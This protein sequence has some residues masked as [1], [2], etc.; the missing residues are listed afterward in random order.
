MKLTTDRQEEASHGLDSR[1][2]CCCT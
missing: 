1:A 2:S